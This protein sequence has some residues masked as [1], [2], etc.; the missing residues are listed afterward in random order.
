[1]QV[2]T[3]LN[4]TDT[5]GQARNIFIAVTFTGACATGHSVKE[6]SMNKTWYYNP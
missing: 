6:S 1:M 3:N 2:M 5:R 4:K